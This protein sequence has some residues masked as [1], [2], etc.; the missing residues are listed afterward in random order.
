MENDAAACQC[1]CRLGANLF[2]ETAKRKVRPVGKMGFDTKSI[3]DAR[4]FARYIPCAIDNDPIGSLCQIKRLIRG[5]GMFRKAR[6]LRYLRPASSG[7]QKPLRRDFPL[8]N[9]NAV[10]P[11][12]DAT[13]LDQ[14]NPGIGQQRSVNGFKSVQFAVLGVD[15]RRP[16]MTIHT[17][18]PA[19]TAG[20]FNLG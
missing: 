3:K 19:V 2:V 7:D 5:N 13:P 17:Q 6:H 8:A 18:L 16:V 9:T 10:G 1:R 12:N 20:I 15:Q 14:F 11:A 4:E